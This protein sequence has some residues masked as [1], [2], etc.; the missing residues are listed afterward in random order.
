VDST[1]RII[2]DHS[3]QVLALT[4]VITL[5][6]IGMLFRL[7]F[8]ADVASFILEGNE[9]GEEFAALQE[10]YDTADPINVM[11]SAPSD[12]N[13]TEPAGLALLAELRDIY[14]DQE[15]VAAVAA[16]APELNPLTGQ[17]LDADTI[18]ALPAPVL[19]QLMAQ[20]PVAALLLSEDGQASL[21]VVVPEDDGVDLARRLQ[22]VEPPEGVE[23][24]LAGNPVI[25]GSVI[26]LLGWFLLVLPPAVMILLLGTFYAAIG[27][28]RLTV[29]AV[30]PAILGSLWTFGVIFGLGFEVD[31]VTVIVPVFVIV[32]GSADGLHFVTHFQEEATRTDDPYERVSSALRQVG[33]PMILTTVSTSAGFLSLLATDVRPIRQLGA[34]VAVGITLAGVISFFSLPALMSRVQVEASHR[35]SLIGPSI[36]TGIQ[37]LVK[38]RVPAL[39]LGAS[40]LLF[41]VFFIPQIEVDSDQL[42]FFKE[43]NEVRLAF[44]AIEEAFGGATP[45]VGEFA[46][47]AADGVAGLDA[48]AATSA[49]IESLPGVRKVFSVAD[50]RALPEPQ[51]QAFL[52]EE[53]ALPLGDMVSADGLR[54]AMF[55]GEFD[56]DDLRG[57]VDYADAHSEVRVLTGMPVLWDETARL[58]LQAQVV[59]VI[60]AFALVA[61]MLGLS[62]RRVG[63]TLIALI[64][65][66]LTTAVLLGFIAAA[67][68]NL[69]LITA[70]VSSIVIGVG[71]DY[72][73]HYIAAIEHARAEGPG[74]VLR[75]IERVGRPIV[76][77][78]LGIAV[79]LTA[80]WISPLKPHSQ[81]SMIM[82]V[83]MM[84]AA[85]STLLIIPALMPRDAVAQQ[86]QNQPERAI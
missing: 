65:I 10:K 46:W 18:A 19:S 36:V 5:L 56:S 85:L 63:Q 15:G 2:V 58:V 57:W 80:L 34:F 21:M 44:N 86:A 72:A 32:M 64:P 16:I 74:Y 11:V 23:V 38:T 1:A 8:N 54:F 68:I 33:V 75:A 3:K 73:I 4:G 14:S 59:S 28:R 70:I 79:A 83:S 9:R 55:P 49:E 51:L 71:I 43:D 37:T 81:I 50:L 42:F 84:T 39:V 30:I 62:Y 20:N 52:N 82:W 13:F 35:S 7:D 29:F 69:N 31:I 60:A 78:A 17:P 6:A 76:A 25:F 26:D 61:I 45:L 53:T 24:T 66:A 12:T 77:N 48:V 40:L 22:E 47:D 41:A 27:D 67:G